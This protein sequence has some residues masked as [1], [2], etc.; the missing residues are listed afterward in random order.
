MNPRQAETV[1]RLNNLRGFAR[2]LGIPE[3]VAVATYER[4]MREL[5]ADAKVERFVPVIAEKRVKDALRSRGRPR[6]APSADT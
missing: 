3:E 5:G 2:G 6:Y 4:E 1:V